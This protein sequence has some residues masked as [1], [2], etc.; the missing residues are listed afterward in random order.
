MK[1]TAPPPQTQSE[2]RHERT[3]ADWKA[4]LIA[5]YEA[6]P[7]HKRLDLW[8]HPLLDSQKAV[9]LFPVTEGIERVEASLALDR[10][11]GWHDFALASLNQLV[12]SDNSVVRQYAH[13]AIDERLNTLKQHSTQLPRSS[14]ESP[15]SGTAN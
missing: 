6:L 13:Q 11:L 12:N 1:E 15:N 3:D 5:D 4:H 2:S 10:L 9:C 8:R 7:V 14:S